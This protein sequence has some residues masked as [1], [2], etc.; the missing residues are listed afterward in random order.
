MKILYGPLYS[1]RLGISVGIDIIP[2]KTCSYNCVY[3]H[4]GETTHLTCS[5]QRFLD[6]EK[7]LEALSTLAGQKQR[8]GLD[9]DYLTFAG[10]GEPTLN[11]ELGRYI[12]YLKNISP[13][14]IA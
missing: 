1:R 6:P 3:C 12:R 7:V 9:I 4:E 14:P 2:Y 10:S 5:R 13:V 11:R 8:R